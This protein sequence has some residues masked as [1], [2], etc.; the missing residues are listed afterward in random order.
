MTER[1][2]A[3]EIEPHADPSTVGEDGEALALVPAGVVFRDVVTQVDERGQLCELFDNRWGIPGGPLV[4]AYCTTIRPGYA[5]GWGWHRDHDDR[6][7]ILF[8]HMETILYDER[9]GS[10]THGLVARV[11]LSELRRRLMTIPAGI[12]HAS[13]NLGERET[14]FVN[15]PT[16]PYEHGSPDKLRLPL[17]NERIPYRFPA[18]T[19]G[20]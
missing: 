8:G 16:H 4:Y 11:V 5:K 9:E 19:R 15:F 13:R 20:G 7:F 18:G 10:P 3:Q 14:V 6:Y 12:W 17:V 2:N 1:R